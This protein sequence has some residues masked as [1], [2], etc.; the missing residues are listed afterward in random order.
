MSATPLRV[1]DLVDA[2]MTAS[3]I[4]WIDTGERTY[5]AW[6]A[7]VGEPGEGG[8]GVGAGG[9]RGPTAYLLNGP[10]EQHLPWL[11]QEV[12]VVLRSRDTGG[13]L[14]R[15]R[16]RR[17]V[18]D[19]ADP[20]WEV[21]AA[22]LSAKRVG[23]TPQLLETWRQQCTVSAL[24]PFGEPL[25]VPGRHTDERVSVPVASWHGAASGAPR[26]PGAG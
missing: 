19:P 12:V 22:A 4:L 16:A 15:L 13:R 17:D 6:H 24:R 7:W 20:E 25:E 14:L 9:G 5:A 26:R 21:A 23:A 10:G 1:S 3:G 18:L 11:P 8:A 2:A